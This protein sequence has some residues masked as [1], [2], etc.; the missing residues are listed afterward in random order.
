MLNS[1]DEVDQPKCVE[2]TVIGRVQDVGFRYF[3]QATARRYG[4]VGWVR[5]KYNGTVEIYAEGSEKA[6]DAFL[7]AVRRGTSSSHVRKVNVKWLLSPQRKFSSFVI[8][9]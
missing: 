9:T 5:N 1:S 2:V 3:A 7:I 4:L 6:I 8:R